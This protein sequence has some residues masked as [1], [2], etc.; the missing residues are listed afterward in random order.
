[1]ATHFEPSASPTTLLGRGSTV[2]IVNLQS[3]GGQA[4]NGKS[5]KLLSF[6]ADADRW[7]VQVDART[8]NLIKAYNLEYGERVQRLIL[9]PEHPGWSM[10]A[11][12]VSPIAGRI[13]GNGLGKYADGDHAVAV[14]VHPPSFTAAYQDTLARK[15]RSMSLGADYVEE[16]MKA[17]V[18]RCGTADSTCDTVDMAKRTTCFAC[19]AVAPSGT[20]F[21]TCKRCVEQK[22]ASPARYC[23]RACQKQ[24][25]KETH[26]CDH[27]QWQF[28]ELAKLSL[29][30][31]SR[32]APGRREAPR[33]QRCTRPTWNFCAGGST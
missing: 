20:T 26:K 18:T 32:E 25:W 5:G 4:L 10:E 28:N 17:I 31:E 19:G 6:D 8:A 22:L 14:Y 16:M 9:T 2:R 11:H 15:L 29:E 23:G 21:M 27:Q 13:A 30:T 33:P 24:H 12:R 7:S 3:A 1:M